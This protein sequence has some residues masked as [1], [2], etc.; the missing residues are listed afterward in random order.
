MARILDREEMA[1]RCRKFGISRKTGHKIF[2][3]CRDFGLDGLTDR[4]R[5]LYRQANQLPLQV[6]S[7]ILQPKQ[8]HRSWGAAKVGEKLRRLDLGGQFPVITMPAGRFTL[9]DGLDR[10][11]M[12]TPHPSGPELSVQHYDASAFWDLPME[13]SPYMATGRGAPRP[14][15]TLHRRCSG[16]SGG[17]RGPVVQSRRGLHSGGEVLVPGQAPF[18]RRTCTNVLPRHLHGRSRRRRFRSGK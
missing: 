5:R 13:P 15:R 7:R 3:R 17:D 9:A 10:V 1:G 8:E 18:L 14:R 16:T 6:E 2:R 11:L 4:S 12:Y